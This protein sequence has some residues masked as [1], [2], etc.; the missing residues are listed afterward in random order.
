MRTY[1][2]FPIEDTPKGRTLARDIAEDLSREQG[3]KYAAVMRAKYR[4]RR[5][6]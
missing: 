2:D 4:E 1:F 3:E 5:R 6:A